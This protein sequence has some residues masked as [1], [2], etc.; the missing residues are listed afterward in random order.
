MTDLKF[1]EGLPAHGGDIYRHGVEMDF[2]VNT[3]PLGP[4]DC[5][6]NAFRDHAPDM[7]HYPDPICEELKE[8]ISTYEKVKSDHIICGN[9]AAELIYCLVEAIRPEEV[10]LIEPGFSE[11]ERALKTVGASCRHYLCRREDGFKLGTDLLD[12]ITPDL[13]MIFLCNPGNPV[14]EVIERSLLIKILNLAKEYYIPVLLDECF[15]DFLEESDAYEMIAYYQEYSNLF[16]LKAFT[17]IFAMPGL[18]LGYGICCQEELLQKMEAL[19]PAWHVSLPAQVCGVAAL[20]DADDYLKET[21]EYLKREREIMIQ[22]LESLGCETYGSKANYIFFSSDLKVKQEKACD[23]TM[24]AK[25]K[26]Q[27]LY[28]WALASKILIRDCSNYPGLGPGDYRIAIK[29]PEENRRF[30]EWLEELREKGEE[31]G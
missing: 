11:Y 5:V 28:K 12:Q 15:I 7:I 27:D 25:K 26:G 20:K 19:L 4:P 31:D 9:G 23:K 8:A 22:K 18:R 2:S 17:K 21:K 6:L 14:G 30:I 13:G 1:S 16:I 3:N 10:L 29:K 24:E